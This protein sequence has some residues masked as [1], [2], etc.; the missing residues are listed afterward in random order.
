MGPVV[1]QHVNKAEFDGGKRF[2]GIIRMAAP[3]FDSQGFA[4]LLSCIESVHSGVHE[5]H[6]SDRAGDGLCPGEHGKHGLCLHG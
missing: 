5:P 1:G 2:D 4:G 3:V 6:H